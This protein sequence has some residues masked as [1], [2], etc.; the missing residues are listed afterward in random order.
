MHFILNLIK[1]LKIKNYKLSKIGDELYASFKK[2]NFCIYELDNNFFKLNVNG[3]NYN[4]LTKKEISN[5]LIQI[6]KNK[7]ILNF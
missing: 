6:K 5:Y 7:F 4:N 1:K 2:Y 3:V